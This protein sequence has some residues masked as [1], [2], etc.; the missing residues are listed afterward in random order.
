MGQTKVE[1]YFFLN[2]GDPRVDNL[3]DAEEFSDL[4]EAANALQITDSEMDELLRIVAGIIH[5]GNIQFQASESDE[6]GSDA[7]LIQTD[8]VKYALQ[9][10]SK[11]FQVP[12]DSLRD[13][14]I[15]KEIQTTDDRVV[16]P[17]SAMKADEARNSMARGIYGR[18]FDWIVTRVN[19][20]MDK[21]L[22]TSQNT[23][24]VLDIF[25]FEIFD[26]NRFEQLC[27]NYCNEKLQQHFNYHIF[28]VEQECYKS[29]GID[30]TS[31]EFIDN[32]EVLDLIE[33]KKPN[34]ILV[35]LD[36]EIKVPKATDETFAN[37]LEKNF[38]N[39][40]RFKP[41]PRSPNMFGIQHYAGTVK[42]HTKGKFPYIMTFSQN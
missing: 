31:V 33:G 10:A 19:K 23:I 30:H 3:D 5:L 32:Q 41:F 14:F 20:A 18:M 28:K 26:D 6:P 24:G 37:K 36:D 34:G 16:S 1:D 17:V 38:S 29:E 2:Q 11:L 35:T 40:P 39:H 22:T 4:L 25:G 12:P 8:S 21:G 42:Y 9:W 7:R 13:A 15:T 27:I